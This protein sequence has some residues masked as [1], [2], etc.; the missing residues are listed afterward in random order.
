MKHGV[1][2]VQGIMRYIVNRSKELLHRVADS[3][4]DIDTHIQNTNRRPV[5]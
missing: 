3:L 4:H 1:M 2:E 5:L